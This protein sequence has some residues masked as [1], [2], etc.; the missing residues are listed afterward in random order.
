M[1]NFF[2]K[3]HFIRVDQDAYSKK[4]SLLLSLMII[5]FF[6]VSAFSF[7]TALYGFADV[8]GCIVS[9]SM[10]VALREFL[11][12]LPLFLL[13]FMAIWCL[14]ALQACFRNVSEEKRKKSLIKDGICILAFGSVVILYVIIG[15]IAGIYSARQSVCIQQV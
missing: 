1:K 15:S 9:G 11:H 5:F 13:T 10:D 2:D 8:V 12:S 6:I 4:Q 14:L 7:L 3:N